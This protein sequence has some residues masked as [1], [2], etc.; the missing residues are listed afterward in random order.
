MSSG[1][2]GFAAKNYR[3]SKNKTKIVS[4]VDEYTKIMIAELVKNLIYNTLTKM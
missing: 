1:E 3:K 4:T 2:N